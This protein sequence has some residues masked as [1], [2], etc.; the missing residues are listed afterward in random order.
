MFTIRHCVLLAGLLCPSLT[1][2]LPQDNIPGA[3][4]TNDDE[5]AIAKHRLTVENV[6]RVFAV[7]RE[8]L[9]LMKRDPGVGTR[10]AELGSRV[11]PNH[12]AGSLAVETKIFEGTPE[13][14]QILQTQGISAREYI[15]TKRVAIGAEMS[16]EAL[17]S[18]ALQ[19]KENSEIAQFMMTSQAVVFWRRMDP[20]LK[21]EA[22]EWKRVREEMVKHGGDN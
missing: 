21:T 3:L 17:K 18:D 2:T 8:L 4:V 7:D 12:S 6:R 9:E 5:R 22:A 20:A 16:D 10:T 13:I 19:Q 15:L 11:D 14:A 1:S